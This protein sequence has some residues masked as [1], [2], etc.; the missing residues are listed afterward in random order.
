MLG[1]FKKNKESSRVAVAY[2]L[3]AKLIGTG[4]NVIGGGSKGPYML[5]VSRLNRKEL[6]RLLKLVKVAKNIT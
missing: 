3:N 1:T 2:K 4:I 6:D 5:T